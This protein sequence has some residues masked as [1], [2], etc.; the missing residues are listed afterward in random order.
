MGRMDL[1]AIAARLRRHGVTPTSQRLKIASVLFSCMEHLSADQ[2]MLAVNR[3]K[4]AASKAT[5][6][7]TLNLFVKKGLVREVI[8]D[9]SKLLFDPRT[10]QH[11]HFYDIA[12]GKL[13]D[14]DFSEL[15]IHSLP[16][17]PHG[18][19]LDGIDIVIRTRPATA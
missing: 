9:P 12:T 16:A 17:L 1:E 3:R 7:N 2:V 5:V 18:T 4:P 11:H 13:S 8:I 6:Y 10:D 14:I 15:P 19:M